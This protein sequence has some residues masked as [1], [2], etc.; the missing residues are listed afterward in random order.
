MRSIKEMMAQ[1]GE[2]L[3]RIQKVVNN[4]ETHTLVQ[5]TEMFMVDVGRTPT[6]FELMQIEGI[7]RAFDEF[8]DECK[9]LPPQGELTV[10]S[11]RLNCPNHYTKLLED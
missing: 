1:Q 8:C 4:A 11:T 6:K 5:L 9:I 3:K 7:R 2:Y 10:V